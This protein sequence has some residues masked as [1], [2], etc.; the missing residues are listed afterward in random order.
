MKL[1]VWLFLWLL[2]VACSLCSM[3]DESRSR[4]GSISTQEDKDLARFALILH[5]DALKNGIG[6]YVEREVRRNIH[7]LRE[8]PDDYNKNEIESLCEL[9]KNFCEKQTS[10]RKIKK[11]LVG[12]DKL[13][14]YINNLVGSAL[15]SYAYEKK[16]QIKELEESAKTK[17]L[18]KRVAIITGSVT[19]LLGVIA[20]FMVSINKI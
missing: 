16:Q 12:D 4:S 7:I 13:S 2:L 20:A 9:H 17:E 11:Q 14:F 3:E 10:E 15:E 1:K 5:G 18:Q 8:S 6:S 19:T